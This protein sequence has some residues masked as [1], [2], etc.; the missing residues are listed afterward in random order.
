VKQP[1]TWQAWDDQDGC[2]TFAPRDR[3]KADRDTG[4][5]PPT[6]V[7]LHELVARTGEEAMMRHHELMGWEPYRPE[8]ERVACPN[9]CGGF[10]YP[11][12]FGDCPNCGHIG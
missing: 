11:Q 5:L 2:I 10:Y 12:G 3:I 4:R 8:G 9:N 6:V 1:I 7:M